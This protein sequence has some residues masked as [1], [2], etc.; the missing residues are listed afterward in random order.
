MAQQLEKLYIAFA[1]VM[2]NDNHI[3]DNAFCGLYRDR[4]NAY[5]GI[6]RIMASSNTP[7]I[8]QVRIAEVLDEDLDSLPQQK[9][10]AE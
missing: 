1:L 3:I 9:V 6:A 10:D 7:Y 8:P 2:D 4:S 5:T